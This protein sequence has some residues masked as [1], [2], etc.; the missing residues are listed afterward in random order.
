MRIIACIITVVLMFLLSAKISLAVSRNTR[1]YKVC[2]VEQSSSDRTI[3]VSVAPKN[4]A[5][6]CVTVVKCEYAEFEILLQGSNTSQTVYFSK[7]PTICD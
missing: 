1:L 5:N 3:Y 7:N 4:I 2:L 6:M